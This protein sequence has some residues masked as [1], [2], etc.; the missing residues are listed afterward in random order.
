VEER[1]R[2]A[3][4]F[5]L[6]STVEGLSVAVLEALKFGLLVLGSD[7]PTLH[8]CVTSGVNG[9]LLPLQ[10]PDQWIEKLKTLL[11]SASLR[12]VLRQQSWEMAK[13]F[14]LEKVADE[15]ELLFRKISSGH[16]KPA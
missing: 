11:C 14:D 12:L 4:I 16:P 5:I 9:Y 7:I 10:A 6:P 3:E 8:D 2:E 13:R 15:Y 1:L